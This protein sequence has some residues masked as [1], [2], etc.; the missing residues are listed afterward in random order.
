MKA[1]AL[2]AWTSAALA[3]TTPALAEYR[4]TAEAQQACTPDVFRLCSQFIPDSGQITACLARQ[5]VNLSPA[6]HQVFGGAR[7]RGH[8]QRLA[9]V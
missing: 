9:N 8:G 7:R 6:C 3:L 5:K 4:G 1:L 2:A